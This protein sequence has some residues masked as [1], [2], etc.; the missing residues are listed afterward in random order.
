M[1]IDLLTED[2]VAAASFYSHLFGWRAAKSDENREYYLFYLDGKP[3]AGMAAMENKDAAA[4]ESL[5]LATISVSD[6]DQRVA[7]VKAQGGKVLEGPLESDE[8][9]KRFQ[10]EFHILSRVRHPHV[11]RPHAWGTHGNRCYFTMDR[12]PGQT[13]AQVLTTAE[14]VTSTREEALALGSH[15]EEHNI[16]DLILV[17]SAFHTKRSRWIFTKVLRGSNV[18]VMVAA[19]PHLEFDAS[20]WWRCEEGLLSFFDEG[21]KMLYYVFHY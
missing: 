16:R 15:V 11:V 9:R 3:I 10:R 14:G 12:L 8:A 1:W 7:S 4:P 18:N 20:N 2:V 5:W 17:T 13:L 21:I 6:V 19:A